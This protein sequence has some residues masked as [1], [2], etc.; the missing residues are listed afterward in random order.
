M[1]VSPV[2]LTPEEVQLPPGERQK[3]PT[4]LGLG[5]A[6]GVLALSEYEDVDPEFDELE[7]SVSGNP[8]SG[9][10]SSESVT[11]SAAHSTPVRSLAGP[12]NASESGDSSPRPAAE[13]EVDAT[14]ADVGASVQ[15]LADFALKLSLGPV[16]RLWVPGVRR[17]AEVLLAAGKQRKAPTLTLV[18]QRLLGLLSNETAAASPA[19]AKDAS[20]VAA[21][22]AAESAQSTRDAASATGVAAMD[23]GAD[24]S[25]AASE[26][27]ATSE[28]LAA[29]ADTA[30]GQGE[31]EA[32]VQGEPEASVQGEPEA[33]VQGEPHTAVPVE[34]NSFEPNSPEPE[35]N[36]PEPNGPEGA[37]EVEALT[38]AIREQVL[39][40][41][42]RLAGLLPEW[43]EAVQDLAEETRRRETRIVRE[44]LEA[45]DGLR[46]DQRARLTEQ[47]RLEELST[48]TPEALAEEFETPKARAEELSNVLTGYRELRQRCE[49]DV[50]NVRGCTH[51]LA[52]LE[53]AQREFEQCDTERKDEQRALRSTRRKAMT[54]LALQL[55]ER[56]E[57]EQLELLEPL[58]FAER[59]ERLRQWLDAAVERPS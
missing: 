46:R 43:P 32:S 30:P 27:V 54:A 53:R 13:A 49:P 7:T 19:V 58:C 15:R 41:V 16:S 12:E 28:S 22:A 3:Q 24:S 26:L 40:E 1:V 48:L 36:S 31:P 39:H 10:S 59:I 2:S 14:P 18:S 42:T 11:S 44:L 9:A 37:V 56:G 34:P 23:S 35:P 25:V 6:I 29:G 50:G 8:A 38:G 55:A 20:G 17:S 51:A 4:L 33:S 45:V 57:L 47:M 5:T 21:P 52:E